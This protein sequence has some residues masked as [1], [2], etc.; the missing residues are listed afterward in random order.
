MNPRPVTAGSFTGSGLVVKVARHILF[1]LSTVLL[2]SG[3]SVS[4]QSSSYTTFTPGSG[5]NDGTYVVGRQ[6]II[7]S[8]NLVVTALMRWNFAETNVQLHPYGLFDVNGN[9]LASA[10]NNPS[11]SPVG[12]LTNNLSVPITLFAGAT[13]YLGSL[14][15]LS[16]DEWSDNT[17]SFSESAVTTLQSEYIATNV[18]VAPV[19][20]GTS[21]T[22]CTYV[23]IG[24]LYT[25]WVPTQAKYAASPSLEDVQVAVNL[26]A[27]GDTVIVPRGIAIWTNT[28]IV[29]VN[30][31]LIGAGQGQTVITNNVSRA[32]NNGQLLWWKTSSSGTC[33]LSGFTFAGGAVDQTHANNSRN[34]GFTGTCHAFRIDH[35]DFE[36]LNQDQCR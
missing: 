19:V 33:R 12:W 21:G 1:G 29:G 27:N 10:I 34:F 16:G 28:L 36:G 20:P 32:V 9:L 31:N 8:S 14:E 25:N 2:L 7:G 23:G 11:G 22:N 30:L 4:A 15:F 17:T 35:C 3:F 5:R 18:L 24:F 6:F 26:C 13:Y